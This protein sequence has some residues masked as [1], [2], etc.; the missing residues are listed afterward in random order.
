VLDDAGIDAAETLFIDDN[1]D[2]IEGA[3]STGIRAV[4]HMANGDIIGL[5]KKEL[6]IE[7]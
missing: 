3:A 2:N 7:L 5:L 6:N 4:H 1:A